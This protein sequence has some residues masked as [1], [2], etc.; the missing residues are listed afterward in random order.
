M[1]GVVAK[2]EEGQLIYIY[3]YARCS[4]IYARCSCNSM[5]PCSKA[6]YLATGWLVDNAA[7]KSPVNTVELEQTMTDG[8]SICHLLWNVLLTVGNTSHGKYR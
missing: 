6:C 3:I 5:G 1:Q 8:G 4:C 2:V 7:A